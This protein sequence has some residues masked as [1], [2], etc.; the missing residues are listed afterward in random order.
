MRRWMGGFGLEPTSQVAPVRYTR[1]CC[2]ES[3]SSARVLN[4]IDCTAVTIAKTCG[5][6]RFE[7]A[8]AG[9]EAHPTSCQCPASLRSRSYLSGPASPA[10]GLPLSAPHA[11]TLRRV[12]KLKRAPNWRRRPV[13]I[14]QSLQERAS[15]GGLPGT[16]YRRITTWNLL[17]EQFKLYIA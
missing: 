4:Y 14:K 10:L 12:P 6:Q 15:Q 1:T 3:S 13:H 5:R 17:H 11:P 7:D 8:A 9:P 16:G 2:C